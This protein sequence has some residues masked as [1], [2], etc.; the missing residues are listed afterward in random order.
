MRPRRRTPHRASMSA[1]ISASRPG[2]GWSKARVSAPS[3]RS[4]PCIRFTAKS[5]VGGR[6]NGVRGNWFSIDSD[7]VARAPWRSLLGGLRYM[8]PSC[9]IIGAGFIRMSRLPGSPRWSKCSWDPVSLPFV[10]PDRSG[11][12]SSSRTDRLVQLISHH[13]SAAGVG[14]LRRCKILLSSI[15]WQSI[16][17]PALSFGRMDLISIRTCCTRPLTTRWSASIA[18]GEVQGPENSGLVSRRINTPPA[19]SP[20]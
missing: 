10:L 3:S 12:R 20:A 6:G 18:K 9:W 13:G 17:R 5:G 2:P 14:S 19:S 11:L 8:R 7:S 15:V 16:A 1:T 4:T